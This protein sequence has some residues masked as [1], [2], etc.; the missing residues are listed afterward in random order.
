MCNALYSAETRGAHLVIQQNHI[1]CQSLFVSS[2]QVHFMFF[3]PAL[4][5][6][7]GLAKPEEKMAASSSII[8]FHSRLF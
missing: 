2:S 3:R 7:F 6:F 4:R 8:V 1:I 5:I